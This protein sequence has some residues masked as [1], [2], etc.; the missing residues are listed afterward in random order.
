MVEKGA[1]ELTEYRLSIGGMACAGCVSAVEEVLTSVDGVKSAVVNLG[2]RT[3]NVS[4]TSDVETLLQAVKKA[5]FEAAELCTLADELEK[6][7]QELTEYRQL[8]WR[9]LTAGSIG[10]LM[11]VTGMG[12]FLP[13]IAE[14]QLVWLF[15]SFITLMVLIFV[16]GHFFSGAW[17]TLKSGR[18]NMDTLVALGT[19]AAWCYSTVVVLFPDSVPSLA[20]HAYFEAAVII[21]A[22]VSLGSALEMRARGKTSDAIK[23]LIGLQ[24]ATARVIRSG[25][26]TDIP[27]S[28]VGL[29]ETIKIVPGDKIP[30][31]G[32][33]I[34]GE[35]YLDES[36]LTGE[37]MPV[38]KIID[39]EV[40]G[41]TLNTTGS[42]MMQA[43]HIGRETA[44]AQIIE[45]VRQ[46]QASK[47]AIGRL[48]DKVAAI[49]VPVVVI[50]SIISFSV[51]YFIGPEPRLSFAMV[52][53][54]T[55]LVIACPCALGLATP[56]SI[57][58]GV[59]RAAEQGIL[60]RNG[61]ALQQAGKLTTVVL[62]K[63][64]TITSGLPRVTSVICNEEDENRLL[65]IATD[66]EA[67][68]EHPLAT[69]ITQ[70]GQ[71]QGF[72]PVPVTEFQAV[73]GKGVQALRDNKQ[74]QLGN[75]VFMQ[76]ASINIESMK[77]KATKLTEQGATPIYV[78]DGEKLLG[79]L[80]VSDPVKPESVQAIAALKQLGLKVVM[81]TGDNKETTAV[82][83]ADVG[84]EIFAAEVL[85]KDK[86]DK[87]KQLQQ[88]G[89]L[90]AMVGDGINDA[91]ALAQADVGIAIG[92]GADVAIESADITLM[93]GA[94]DKVVDAI[95]LSRAILTNIKQNLF[96]AFIYNT[97]GLPV[98]AG[99]LYPI[100]GMLLSPVVAA[101]AMSLSSV[102][103]VS[104]A[105]RLRNISL[106]ASDD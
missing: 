32:K 44:L 46:A 66:L 4:A 8:W 29:D 76:E 26:E 98:A 2:E 30:V 104:N 101:T 88:H 15:I 57:M 106:R 61:D 42:F 13:S 74:A 105:L 92:T 22:L 87:I 71:K 1:N 14:G 77:P 85:P 36:L 41:G 75:A 72:K 37:S 47:P 52:S 91:P 9:A 86:S 56:I 84:I 60:I 19:G 95:T 27:L 45:M 54:I 50:I 16:G 11:F 90:V 49:F 43:T 38:K 10:V 102:T 55:V 96:G 53:A 59:G 31:D 17:K 78:A 34:E 94:L 21:V 3:A 93:S 99:V 83:A 64:G 39:N 100:T 40:F 12:G 65:Q 81:L 103:V 67:G 20:R 58:V 28:E 82:V 97:L 68:S 63:T 23:K 79:I 80:G 73:S 62:D 6:E 33:V 70:Y 5:G 18:G 35:S 7:N 89:E 24:P 48:V 51:W 69:A 25:E